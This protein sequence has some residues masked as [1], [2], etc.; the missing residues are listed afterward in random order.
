M[1]ISES[2]TLIKP[3]L[4]KRTFSQSSAL[5]KF[6]S[7]LTPLKKIISRAFAKK[8][9]FSED[10]SVSEGLIRGSL[11]YHRLNQRKRKFLLCLSTIKATPLI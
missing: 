1:N 9:L 8:N 10:P 4:A 6:I 2:F 7:E 11:C 3:F 5:K